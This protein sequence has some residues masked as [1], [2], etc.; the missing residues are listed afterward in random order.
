MALYQ[1][2][3]NNYTEKRNSDQ[4]GCKVFRQ[5]ICVQCGT[6]IL[7]ERWEIVGSKAWCSTWYGQLGLPP[8]V[9]KPEQDAP[10]ETKY[11]VV[12]LPIEAQVWYCPQCQT[13]DP[14]AEQNY[15]KLRI[16]LH[17]NQWQ[18]K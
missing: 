16:Q 1:N 13:P 17:N 5:N 8:F 7:S 18:K 12:N 14:K 4:S 10:A 2:N 11:L 6:K 9:S 3:L 15:N